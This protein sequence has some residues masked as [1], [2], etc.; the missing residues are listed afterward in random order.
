MSQSHSHWVFTSFDLTLLEKLP[1]LCDKTDG[2][3]AVYVVYQLESAPDTRREHIQGYVEYPSRVGLRTAKL[4]LGDTT[5]HVE[6]RRGKRRLPA[7]GCVALI[8]LS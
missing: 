3:K 6:P 7:H 4:W 2:T 1:S 5:A 8:Y